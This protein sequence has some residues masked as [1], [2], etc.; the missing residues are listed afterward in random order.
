V[1]AGLAAAAL[2]GGLVA[3]RAGRDGWAFAGTAVAIGLT[4]ATLFT[5]L[6]PDVLPSTISAANSLT[7]HN[8][9]S[10]PYTLKIMTWVAAAF[11]PV[12]L[13]YQGWT[14]WVFRRRISVADIPG[15]SH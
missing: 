2:A 13:L 10:T 11:A 9:A 4:V 7:V 15:G 14:Y 3:T 6:Y 5:T 1:L 12:V 8:A